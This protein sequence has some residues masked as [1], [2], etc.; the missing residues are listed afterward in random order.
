MDK[1]ITKSFLNGFFQ[2]GKLSTRI[3]HIVKKYGVCL[4]L[5]WLPIPTL[6]SFIFKTSTSDIP[7]G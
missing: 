7:L 1:L 4:P 6:L 5:P 2:F 3:K